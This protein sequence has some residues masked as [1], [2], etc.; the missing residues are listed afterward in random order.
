MQTCCQKALYNIYNL[1]G[2]TQTN[3]YQAPE[4]HQKCIKKLFQTYVTF[5]IILLT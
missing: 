4:D 1:A 2:L 3:T 5:H